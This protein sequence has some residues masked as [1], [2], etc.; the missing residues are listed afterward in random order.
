MSLHYAFVT[1]VKLQDRL[2]KYGICL[3]KTMKY[4]IQK[5]IGKHFLDKAVQLVKEGKTFFCHR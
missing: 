2:H 5:E 3:G 4:N 1:F